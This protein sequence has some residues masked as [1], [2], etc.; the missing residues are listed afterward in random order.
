MTVPKNDI[1]K[2]YL[3][4]AEH[5]LNMVASTTDQELRCIHREMAAEWLR[6]AD[7][8]R[9]HR[10]KRMQMG[11]ASVYGGFFRR[12]TELHCACRACAR[13]PR[14]PHQAQRFETN[15]LAVRKCRRRNSFPVL[16]QGDLVCR[17]R[18]G[19]GALLGES[20][21]DWRQTGSTFRAAWHCHSIRGG[22]RCCIFFPK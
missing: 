10:S 17:D 4:Y 18:N 14:F 20:S 6:L 19:L 12:R 9:R 1:Y 5:C 21:E 7:V 3:R 11:L 2:D 8:V 22:S 16:E 15:D 13:G